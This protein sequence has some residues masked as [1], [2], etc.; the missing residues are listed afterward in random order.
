MYYSIQPLAPFNDATGLL[1]PEEVMQ[2][3]R[4]ADVEGQFLQ[5]L[6][7]GAMQ[8]AEDTC[9]QPLFERDYQVNLTGFSSGKIPSL[10]VPN[11]LTITTTYTL[12]GSDE[13]VTV[14]AGLVQ[15]RSGAICFD[16][17]LLSMT[18]IGEVKMVMKL[19][20]PFTKVPETIKLALQY[21]IAYFFDNRDD[22]KRTMPTVSD[23]LLQPYKLFTV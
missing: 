5:S 12:Q 18:N 6:I 11:T 7:F 23:C 1:S 22:S 4:V 10:I 20:Y 19:G 3:L 13:I 14:D 15:L 21:M 9:N 2:W 16:S 8:M 17:T